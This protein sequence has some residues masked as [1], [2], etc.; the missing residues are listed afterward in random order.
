[1]SGGEASR[2]CSGLDMGAVLVF[3]RRFGAGLARGVGIRGG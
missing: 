2:G 3:R 1:M